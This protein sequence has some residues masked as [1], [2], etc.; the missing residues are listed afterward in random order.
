MND[1]EVLA[2]L[3]AL[4]LLIF[5]GPAI[6]RWIWNWQFADIYVFTY[7]QAFWLAV[8]VGFLRSAGGF[9]VST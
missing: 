9:R 8:A 4:L 7:W 2:K 1:D 6:F 5:V 3:V